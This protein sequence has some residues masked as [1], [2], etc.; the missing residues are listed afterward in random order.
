MHEAL[1]TKFYLQHDSHISA[2]LIKSLKIIKG[3]LNNFIG[4]GQ[5]EIHG[6]NKI[7]RG[8]SPECQLENRQILQGRNS[9][10]RWPV[11]QQDFLRGC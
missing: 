2:E 6:G 4:P 3:A 11:G 5:H 10:V 8:R 1:Q 7:F 9:E